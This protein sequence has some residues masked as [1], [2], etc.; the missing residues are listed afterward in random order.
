MHQKTNFSSF[1]PKV[2]IIY[3]NRP[4]TLASESCNAGS[5]L[6]KRPGFFKQNICTQYL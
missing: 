1:S 4:A 5:V 3:Y 2:A 6:P